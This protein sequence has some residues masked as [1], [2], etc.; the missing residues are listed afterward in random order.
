MSSQLFICSCVCVCVFTGPAVWVCVT[1]WRAQSAHREEGGRRRRKRGRREWKREWNKEEKGK[2]GSHSSRRR[3]RSGWMCR[4]LYE[5]WGFP[6]VTDNRWRQ[7]APYDNRLF[8]PGQASRGGGGRGEGGGERGCPHLPRSGE[9]E[10]TSVLCTQ[11]QYWSC[12]CSLTSF[13]WVFFFYSFHHIFTKKH[14]MLV[15]NLLRPCGACL[16]DILSV[17][18]A[19]QTRPAL[20][21]LSLMFVQFL[22]LLPL[23]LFVGGDKLLQD[24]HKSFSACVCSYDIS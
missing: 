9:S 22:S 11:T 24:Q 23:G 18:T 19:L 16:S 15:W 7:G 4:G 17:L 5:L 20:S 13:I 12:C 14:W 1:D 21:V 2:G 6:T 8:D 3:R 10:F